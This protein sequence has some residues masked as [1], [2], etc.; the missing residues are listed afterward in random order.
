MDQARLPKGRPAVALVV[1]VTLL[2]LGA[3]AVG[4]LSVPS[5]ATPGN[6][7][8]EAGFLRDMQV[9][10]NQAVEMSMLVRGLTDDEEIRLLAY[11]IATTQA[12]QNGQMYGW[13]V[14]W[15]LPQ[16]SPEPSM[17][18]MTRPALD[19]TGHDHDGGASTHRPGDPMPGLASFEEM[20][21]LAS[22]E[23]VAA[24]RLFLELMIEHHAG[25]VEMAEAVIARSNYPTVVDLATGMAEV[26]QA[27]IELMRQLLDE[28]R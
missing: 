11:D 3:F 12:H 24:E 16:A 22:L 2:V 26:Q 14:E 15:G 5:A 20:Q 23:G 25:G 8:A 6:T 10:H 19:G 21:R 7:S 4:R 9:H 13:L 27:E 1:A 18:W 28:R 17:T